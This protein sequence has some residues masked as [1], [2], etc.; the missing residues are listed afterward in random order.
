MIGMPAVFDR[1]CQW[2]EFA[3]RYWSWQALPDPTVSAVIAVAVG[4]V[5]ALWGARL[6][7]A[8]FVLGLMAAGAWVG[9]RI[10]RQ[11][12]VDPLI[13]LVIG[14]GLAGL[15]GHLLYRW[16]V[17]LTAGLCMSAMV[18]LAGAPWA[19]GQAEAFADALL[20]Q[21]TGE[22]LFANAGVAQLPPSASAPAGAVGPGIDWP[23]VV[24]GLHPPGDQ[25]RP[26]PLTCLKAWTGRI[27][28]MVPGGL[29]NLGILVVL[30]GLLG[31]ALGVVLPRLTTIVGTSVIGVAAVAAGAT[32][33]IWRHWPNT[34]RSIQANS[35]WFYGVVGLL[36]VV[37]LAFQARR[38][39]LR[40]LAPAAPP[41]PARRPEA[42]CAR[43]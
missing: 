16:W 18:V 22:R 13:G 4:L 19:V 38:G 43:G 25:A 5:L 29:K 24:T 35:L 9:I 41:A 26:T 39:K 20:Q 3:R 34:W 6:M 15:I 33:L 37:S 8:V 7:R 36:L 1:L 27:W 23:T 2:A 17:G 30:A 40:H 21:A 12:E 28:T 14:A 11:Y 31:L 10:A 42:P 32:H